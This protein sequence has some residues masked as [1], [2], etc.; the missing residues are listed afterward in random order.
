M[1]DKDYE[2]DKARREA[3]LVKLRVIADEKREPKG[4]DL[5]NIEKAKQIFQDFE[6]AAGKRVTVETGSDFVRGVGQ[7]VQGNL[8][9]KLSTTVRCGG[10]EALAFLLDVESRSLLTKSDVDGEKVISEVRQAME[11]L[12]EKPIK[13]KEIEDFSI[14]LQ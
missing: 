7:K 4:E 6:R 13:K 1:F 5:K 2:I 10:E 9:C 12:F 3:L 14:C 8:W 11:I